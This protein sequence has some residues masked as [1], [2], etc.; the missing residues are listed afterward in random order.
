MHLVTVLWAQLH[1]VDTIYRSLDVI[2]SK[3]DGFTLQQRPRPGSILMSRYTEAR[4]KSGSVDRDEP[5]LSA[6][7]YQF[8]TTRCRMFYIEGKN[9]Q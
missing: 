2:V 8:Y 7:S 6:A 4:L 3:K 9:P 1:I 5:D